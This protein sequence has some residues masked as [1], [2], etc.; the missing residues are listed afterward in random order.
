MF[1]RVALTCAAMSALSAPAAFGQ[2]APL[3]PVEQTALAKDA[4][5]TGLLDRNA[6]ALG[7]DL[8]RGA[9]AA[10]LAMLL[11]MAPVRPSGPATGA[12]MRRVLLSP[13]EAPEGAT[14]ALGGAKLKAL[15]RAG[16][17][18]E[19]RQIESLAADA[20]NDPASIEAMAIADILSNDMQAACGKGRRVTAGLDNAF[21]VRL[22][23]VCYAA[24][25]ELDAAELALGILSENGRL[26]EIDE[27]LLAPLASGGKPKAPVAP[28]DAIHL[29]A[30]K[31]MDIPLSEALLARA[32]AGVVKAVA[33][34]ETADWP[35]RLAAAK[36]AAAS[37]VMSGA[38]LK[39]VYAAAP[40][41]ATGAYHDIRAMTAPE[42][43]RDRTGL[44]ASEIAAASDFNS[45][46]AFSVLYADDIR[47]AEGAILPTGEAA[48]LALARLAVGD[49]V[50]S[51]RW[52]QSAAADIARGVPE[53]E[54]TRF[55][56]IVGVLHALE[57]AGAERVAAAA[58]ISVSPPQSEAAGAAAPSPSLAPVVAAA[59]EA[60]HRGSAGEAALAALAAS[61]AAAGGDP[62]ANAMMA[63]A[64]RAAG[65]SDIV[66]RRAV[67]AAIG[68]LYPGPTATEASASVTPAAAPDKLKPRL[69]PKR[70]A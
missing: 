50:G 15:A 34:D 1:K 4:F 59:I 49:A 52:L 42:L 18:E 7:S 60:A 67:E 56:D 47:G 32:D 55:I 45:L 24:S 30:L 28:V 57:P 5:S 63:P 51:E 33:K 38:D 25:N 21:W 36:R 23:V 62:I 29:A 48:S 26:G 37:G 66:R 41:E 12:A 22:R 20:N 2:T 19:A 16:F 11:K 70:S 6:G 3:A 31:A 61:D 27:A 8:W 9:D 35:T 14:A 64:L 46:F 10:S 17:I 43:L 44:I 65:L 58:N 13:G 54:A 40:T 39:A 53:S 69:K 68:V